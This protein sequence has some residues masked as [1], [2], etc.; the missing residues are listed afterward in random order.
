MN[1]TQDELRQ[2]AFLSKKQLAAHTGLSAS[3]IQR[4]KDA[5]KI[6]FFQPGGSGGKLLFPIG[7]IEAARSLARRDQYGIASA[8]SGINTNQTGPT[9]GHTA[10]G[11]KLSGPRPR[12]RTAKRRDQE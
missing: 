3:T 7:V 5:G 12:W 1:A 2:P 6:P 10:A 11:D 8:S 4:H 9:A